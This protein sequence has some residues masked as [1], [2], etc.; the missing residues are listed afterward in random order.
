MPLFRR[1]RGG[2]RADS[3]TRVFFATDIHGS[4]L[5]FKKFINA[6]KF[7]GATHL[8]MGGDITGKS[9][10]AV[11]ETRH[12]WM[13]NFREHDYVC[14][15]S[16]ELANVLQAIRDSGQ[17]PFVCQQDELAALEDEGYR[18][19]VFTRLVVEGIQ[20]WMDIA[21]DRL[22]HT[23][24]QCYVTPGNDDFWEIDP[25]IVAA[26]AVHFVEGQCVS[27]DGVHEMITT[28]YSNPTPWE[29][30][31]EVTE[32]EFA[33]K[34]EEMW[35]KVQDPENAVAVIH[36]PPINT[37]LDQA[38]ELGSDLSLKRGAGGLKMSHVGSSAVRMWLEH[39]QPLCGLH[40]HV[41][42]SKGTESIGRTLC[43]NP[44]SEYGEGIL[45]G[46]LIVLGRGRVVSHQF[47]T[48]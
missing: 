3:G 5:C 44:G 7:Y 15:T 12:G 40:G 35:A 36:A 18:A 6:G 11:E 33:L 47:V 39:A 2:Y 37:A 45:A 22:G 8:V 16:S 29:T 27:L 17:Y 23:Q 4:D 20:R 48:G 14:T 28:G 30:E 19:T 25:I 10:I 1:N 13:A 41:H 38:P 24:I 26:P 31:R 43:L 42:E 32:E 34:L 9:I 21:T 46:A